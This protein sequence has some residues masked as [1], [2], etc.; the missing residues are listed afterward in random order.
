MIN[1]LLI[2]NIEILKCDFGFSAQDDD[3]YEG[4]RIKKYIMQLNLVKKENF[5]LTF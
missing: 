2:L 5:F 4:K 1:Q 3:V